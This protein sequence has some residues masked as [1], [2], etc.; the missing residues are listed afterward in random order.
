[1]LASE[2]RVAALGDAALL[3]QLP[4]QGHRLVGDP[5]LRIVKEEAGALGGEALAALRV[6][7]EDLA[8]VA[9][10]K[11]GVVPLEGLPGLGLAKGCVGQEPK[12]L[13]PGA[14]WRA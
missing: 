11:I 6:L 4:E 9:L 10:A 7:G 13:R 3:R 1:V 5:V 8:Q 14:S 2:H 12:A